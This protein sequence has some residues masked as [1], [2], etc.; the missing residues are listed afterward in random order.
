MSDL[1]QAVA[2]KPAIA[3]ITYNRCSTLQVLLEGLTKHCAN[4]PIA[5]F[6]DCGQGDGTETFLRG[7]NTKPGRGRTELMAVEYDGTHLGPKVQVFLGTTN[8][9][10]TGNSNRALKWFEETGCDHLCL[11]NDDLHVEGD[12]VNFYARGHQ[13]LGVGMFC[14]C[15]FTHHESYRWVTVHCRGWKVKLCPRMTGIMMSL[16]RPV[17]QR[18]GYFDARFGRMGQ[19]HCDYTNRARFAGFVSLAGQ[20]QVQIDLDFGG[21]PMLRHQEGR[22][23][24]E[25]VE[26]RALDDEAAQILAYVAKRYGQEPIHRPFCLRLPK[27]AGGHAGTGVPVDNLGHY[28]LVDVPA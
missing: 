26:R 20:P 22:S 27:I 12:F 5:I 4:Y 13:D 10:V 16:T 23:S 25:G 17:L 6:E 18:V 3:V 28:A 24:V 8:L 7:P 21:K 19:E 9:G 2:A 14:F 15:D 1:C 11:L